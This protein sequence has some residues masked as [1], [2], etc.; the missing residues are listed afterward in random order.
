MSGRLVAAVGSALALTAA[1][2]FFAG[3]YVRDNLK[4]WAQARGQRRSDGEGT[5]EAP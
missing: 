4:R 1:L 5:P 2:G 3:W